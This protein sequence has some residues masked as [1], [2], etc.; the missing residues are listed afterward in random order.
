MATV[1]S[2]E[3]ERQR[4]LERRARLADAYQSGDESLL[5]EIQLINQELRAVVLAIEELQNTKPVE[6]T[7]Q[8]VANAQLANDDQADTQ[9]PDRAPG[10]IDASGTVNQQRGVTVPSN[11]ESA[12]TGP[13]VSPGSPPKLPS[14]TVTAGDTPATVPAGS[15][16]P[17]PPTQVSVSG[18]T[19]TPPDENNNLVSYIYRATR[20]ISHFRQGKFTQEIEGVQVFFTV[21]PRPVS[22]SETLRDETGQ[23]SNIRRNTETGELYV[24]TPG[25]TYASDVGQNYNYSGAVPTGQPPQPSRVTSAQSATSGVANENPSS[26]APLTAS[27]PT[28]DTPN[29]QTVPAVG[30]RPIDIGTEGTA[31]IQQGAREY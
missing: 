2:L 1:Q 29:I 17:R 28:S 24:G 15:S 20:V 4:L 22:G 9:A 5:P 14:G 30:Q 26:T 10:A 18:A 8:T 7:G 12:D 11:A 31:N 13:V 6:S 19:V 27:P 23:V 3:A 16:S 25:V 21:P